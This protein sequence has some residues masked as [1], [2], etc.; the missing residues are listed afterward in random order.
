MGPNQI[1]LPAASYTYKHI[2]LYPTISW[3]DSF[4]GS[5][6]AQ[7]LTELGLCLMS[8]YIHFDVHND[9]NNHNIKDNG[10]NKQR[11]PR[12]KNTNMPHFYGVLLQL[13]TPSKPLRI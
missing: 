6:I 5:K 2:N 9:H 11:L 7:G 10:D 1:V 3:V 12:I 13:D 4:M 8:V